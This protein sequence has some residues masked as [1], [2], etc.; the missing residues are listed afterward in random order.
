[1]KTTLDLPDDL[2]LEAKSMAL[3]RRTTLKS[4]VEH[5]LRREIQG[6]QEMAP[7]EESRFQRNELGFL[8]LKRSPSDRICLE[9][10]QRLE[11]EMDETEIREVLNLPGRT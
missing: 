11:E 1:M 9:D 8:M 10:I 3:R 2:L 4:L 5:A 6:R 7:N